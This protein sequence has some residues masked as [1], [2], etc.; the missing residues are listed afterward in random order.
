MYKNLPSS[1]KKLS[2]SLSE[3]FSVLYQNRYCDQEDFTIA[4]FSGKGYGEGKSNNR[5]FLLNNFHNKV[6]FSHLPKPNDD[7]KAVSSGS[8]IF[9]FGQFEDHSSSAVIKCSFFTNNLKKLPYLKELDLPY[10]VCSFMKKVFVIINRACMF[11]DKQRDQWTSADSMIESRKE[12]ACTVFEGKIVVSGGSRKVVRNRLREGGFVNIKS[13]HQSIEAYDFH[14]NK[15]SSFP[16]MLSPRNNHA[17]VSIGNKMFMVGGSSDYVEVFDS[18][19]RKFTYIENVPKLVRI[20]YIFIS[21]FEVVSI[22]YKIY[23]FR[24]EY[25]KVHVHSYDVK[26]NHFSF[27]TPIE[28]ENVDKFSCIRVPMI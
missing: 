14:E 18:V 27:K 7:V 22:G 11:Y 26:N 12:A 15:W 16:N 10:F 13:R 24:K 8:D 17:A 5:P 4:V 20:P 1:S 19:T 3:Q 23:I 21:T 28:I 9:V 6:Y 25:N 2:K